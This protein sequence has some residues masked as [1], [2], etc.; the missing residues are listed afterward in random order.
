MANANRVEHK[1]RLTSAKSHVS[2]GVSLL[3]EENE[4]DEVNLERDKC[5]FST[6]AFVLTETL[7]HNK[8]KHFAAFHRQQVSHTFHTSLFILFRNLRI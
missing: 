6:Q 7:L 5:D 4:D 2:V 8:V 3:L 1:T